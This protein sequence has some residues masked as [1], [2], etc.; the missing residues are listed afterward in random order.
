MTHAPAPSASDAALSLLDPIWSRPLQATI[1]GGMAKTGTTLPLTLLDGHPDLLV[2]PEE[3]RF[4][5][6][7]AH[8][9]DAA[10]AADAFL[11]NDNIR[12]L[13]AGARDFGRSDYKAHGGT[14][15]GR[16]DY[17]MFDWDLFE[18]LVRAGFAAR[19]RPIDRF[20]TLIGAYLA[21]MGQSVDGGPLHFVCKAPHNEKYA[22][23]WVRM[24]GRQ[25]RYIQCTRDPVEHYMS[26]SNL[27]EL[28]GSGPASA[29][30][31]ARKVR[32]RRWLWSIYPRKRLYVLDYDR[33]TADPEAEMH[34]I[35]T[36]M[37]IPFHDALCH[38][39]KNGV[40]WSGNSSRGLVAEKVFV[41]PSVA[42]D[43]VSPEDQ[44]TI[45]SYLHRFMARMGWRVTTR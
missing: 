21:A 27:S 40:P 26:L 5:H 43:T 15:F 37:G 38:P 25:G 13:S 44:R 11:G 9:R 31:F 42:R 35:A 18:R 12:R 4:F 2:F 33:L 28:Y 17:S 34:K 19:A 32:R 20:R 14:G 24:L 36:F 10:Q 45:E 1:I 29:R 22:L 3:F 16:T 6:M 8:G 39:T 7:K 23:D 30:D 41:N